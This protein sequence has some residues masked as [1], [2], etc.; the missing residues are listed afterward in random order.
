MAVTD[1]AIEKL[2]GMIVSGELRPGEPGPLPQ[3]AA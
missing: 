3:F 2:K 1:E